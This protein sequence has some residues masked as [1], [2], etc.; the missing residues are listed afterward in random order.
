MFGAFKFLSVAGLDL[1]ARPRRAAR[2]AANALCAGVERIR[3]LSGLI[4]DV[5]I[6]AKAIVASSVLVTCLL[7]VGTNAYLSLD[8]SASGLAHLSNV[9]IPKQRT[10]WSLTR[11]ITATHLKIFRLAT[12]AQVGV[13]ENTL[14]AAGAE[15]LAELQTLGDRLR[16]FGAQ[17]HLS[18][19]EIESVA[20]LSEKWDRYIR[21]IRDVISAAASDA[22]MAS[23]LLGATDDEFQSIVAALQ[24]TSALVANQTTA[25]SQDLTIGTQRNRNLLALG[26]ALGVFLSALVALLVARSVVSPIRAVT[27]AMQ[28]VSSGQGR[29]DI[30]Y[31]NRKDEIGQMVEAIAV[32]QQTMERQN[33]LLANRQDELRAQNLRFD[34]ALNHM[35]QGLAMFD[36]EHRLVVCNRLY[37]ELYGL[38]V[39]QV[40]PGTTIRQLLEYRHA[41]GVFGD[42]D[43]ETFVRDWLAGFSKGA[44][45]IQELPDGRTFSIV[46]R[47]MPGGGLVSTTED[48]TQRRRSEAKIAHMARHDALTELPNRVLLKER[49]EL[50]V[51]RA[52]LGEF[53]A[54]HLLDLDHFKNVNDTLGHP[55]G[56]NL[57]RAVTDR[58]RRLVG[59]TDTIARMGGDEFAI[60]Q[61]GLKQPAD[62]AG[63]A[64]KVIEVVR[65][66][67]EIDGHQV[68][69][70]TSVGIAIGPTDGVGPDQ[71]IRNAD[72]ALYRAKG[73][74]RGIFRFFEAEMDAHMKARRRM[75]HDLRKALVAGEF[76]LYYQP[77]VNLE[78]NEISGCEALIRW[79]HPE[80]GMISPAD[81]IPLAEEN[82][83][84]VPLGEWAIR[85]ASRT[86]TIWP[87]HIKIAV[88]LSPVQFKSPGLVQAVLG[89]LATSGLQPRRLELEITERVLLDDNAATLATLHHLR[90]LGVRVVMD[91]FGTGYSSL[92][93]LQSFP[94]DKIKID[95]SFIKEVA[96]RKS[97][98]DIVRAMA[99]LASGLGMATTAEGVETKEQLDA[100]KAEGCTEMQGFLFSRPLPAQEVEH[101]LWS[102]LP[103]RKD[104]S[105][106]A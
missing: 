46:R 97:A 13:A 80:K 63:L 22:S 59:E 56:D 58:L 68:V 11:D 75:E 42:V 31:R 57:L 88:N 106:A 25:T 67:H 65:E 87:E 81:F 54:V 3:R 21:E 98:V 23:M 18:P 40:K 2:R 48:I 12:W 5:P 101:L 14:T 9:Q 10:A 82:G 49:L 83:F 71:L 29:I 33:Q 20:M 84:I 62:A 90:A 78:R 86:A 35:S 34:T 1:P 95:R 102:E 45:R 8:R 61:V 103:G 26:G 44:S 89:A 27:R 37:A 15:V 105:T 24:R 36:A 104:V 30:G 93:Y 51:A 4:D 70:G 66:P 39:E 50:A 32:F 16:H 60:V 76:E 43:F 92:S 52:R 28:G 96:D 94:F 47:P 38:T 17:P 6:S 91:D 53:T 85:E 41:R 74:G 100:V 19:A 72:L 99:A 64:Q 69:A 77:L 7:G 79:R 73:D 55:V